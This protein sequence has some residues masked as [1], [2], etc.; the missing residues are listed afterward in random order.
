MMMIACSWYS[1]HFNQFLPIVCLNQT[2]LWW[3][4][5]QLSCMWSIS[6]L[7]IMMRTKLITMMMMMTKTNDDD[8]GSL[9]WLW[10]QNIGGLWYKLGGKAY[11]GQN[12]W[13]IETNCFCN[14]AKCQRN[15]YW[16]F[17]LQRF[18]ISLFDINSFLLLPHLYLTKTVGVWKYR[19]SCATLWMRD[20][21]EWIVLLIYQETT[22][23]RDRFR[24][25]VLEEPLTML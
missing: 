12:S 20:S 15:L 9:G 8:D 16:C 1:P 18:F 13:Q 23:Q 17:A 2:N 11:S 22:I 6:I 10:H 3:P 4:A 5:H 24:G 21:R 14:K 19:A 7:V 25:S